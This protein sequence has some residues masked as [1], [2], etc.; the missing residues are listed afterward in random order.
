MPNH[1]PHTIKNSL[2][3]KLK[4]LYDEQTLDIMIHIENLLS[5]YYPLIKKRFQERTIVRT[6]YKEK[7]DHRDIFLIS[8]ANSLQD[9]DE[10]SLQT[11]Y[12][13]CGK[14]IMGKI[15]GIHVLPFNTW[16]TDRGFSVVNFYEVDHR[17][18]SWEDFSK[19]TK[20][21]DRIMVDC[22]LNHASLENPI[23]QN[24]LV[25]DPSYKNYIITYTD[26]NKP[27]DA[28][29]L[30]ITRTRPTPILTKYYIYKDKSGK[31]I[32]TFDEPIQSDNVISVS[33]GWTWTTF[34][35]PD[36][37]DGTSATRQVDLN[38]KNPK[39]LLEFIEILLFYISKGSSWIRLDAVGYLWKEIGTTCLHLP[40]THLVIQIFADILKVLEQFSITFI[41]EVNE[42]QENALQYLGDKS[43]E[44]D[45]VYLFTHF[46]L[47]VHAI[48]TGTSKYYMNWIPSIKDA[49]GRLFNG[50]FGTHD[51]MGMKP[52]GN[53]LPEAEKT[54]LQ[55][56]LVE[57][58]RA[59]PNYT[60]IP[61]GKRIIYEL[62]ATPW[63]YIN[64]SNS[65]EAFS[66]QLKRY[67]ALLSLGLMIK[68]VPAIYINGLLG[69]SNFE[70][71]LEENRLINREILDYNHVI[72]QLEDKKSKTSQ[73]FNEIIRLIKI[74][75][76]EE[77]F[78]PKGDIEPL[79]VHE[80]VISVLI[81]SPSNRNRILAL[82][83]VSK[84]NLKVK[85]Q[86]K[87]IQSKRGTD[88]ITETVINFNH[89][90]KK[91]QLRAYQTYWIKLEEN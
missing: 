29:I 39:V 12:K 22:V 21:F 51:G 85:I 79:F 3:I 6:K 47:A 8:Y 68:S 64:E 86:R 32:V 43:E 83:N 91:L 15:T 13:F 35:R 19:L 73:I 30:K 36:N 17:N 4:K 24:A 59:L 65:D 45:M 88:L 31:K 62:C 40:E 81:S 16:D 75:V 41:A 26:E 52:I 89:S 37:P 67:I 23:I 80:N 49:K 78:D 11:L 38:Y 69:I 48:L 44:S 53:W 84:T 76:K 27:S 28:E 50:I 58:H 42:P 71:N 25:G 46:P 77:A 66:L 55:K 5:K 9:S 72:D 61:G 87:M 34:S 70:G 90:S 82:V 33:T 20:V 63:S 56:L 60:K 54:I 74:R 14:Y 18:G 1:I 2:E 10:T 7:F 57:K